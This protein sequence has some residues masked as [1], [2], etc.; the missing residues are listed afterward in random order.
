M[1]A[2]PPTFSR[3]LFLVLQKEVVRVWLYCNHCWTYV[4]AWTKTSFSYNRQVATEECVTWHVMKTTIRTQLIFSLLRQ[5]TIRL[6]LSLYQIRAH[7][8]VLFRV[9]KLSSCQYLQTSS[10]PSTFMGFALLSNM[11]VAMWLS[12]HLL[13]FNVAWLER[14]NFI[15]WDSRKTKSNPKNLENF[16][17][18]L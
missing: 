11:Q 7:F 5:K 12:S 3:T 17:Q 1:I 16:M 2:P 9:A 18:G 10:G 14:S 15:S 4:I 13:I 6:M 8:H